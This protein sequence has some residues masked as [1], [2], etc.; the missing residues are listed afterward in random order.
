[1]AI[2]GPAISKCAHFVFLSTNLSKKAAAEDAP[3]H[4]VFPLLQISPYAPLIASLCSSY[5][6]KCHTGSKESELALINSFFIFSSFVKRPAV[7]F[8]RATTHAPVS[9]AKSINYLGLNS[10]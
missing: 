1:M 9:V 2:A 10:F 6:G 5:I 8:P 7:S 4:L 3:P